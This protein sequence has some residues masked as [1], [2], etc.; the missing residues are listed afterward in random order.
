MNC[1]AKVYHDDAKVGDDL[2]RVYHDDATVGDD[3]S[4]VSHDDAKV[5]DDVS[6]V[7]HDEAT[8]GECK[9]DCVHIVRCGQGKFTYIV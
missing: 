4:R 9:V 5:G 3:E 1:T 8:V 6:R 7:S 2:L